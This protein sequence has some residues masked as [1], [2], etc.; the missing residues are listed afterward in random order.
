M[1]KCDYCDFFSRGGSDSVGNDYVLS[2]VHEADYYARLYQIDSF[3]TIYIGGGTPSL[4][5]AP[6]LSFLLSALQKRCGEAEEITLEMNPETLDGEKLSA[7]EEHGVSRL[8]VGVQSLTD[9]ALAS[10]HRHCSVSQTLRA[11]SLIQSVWHGEVNLDVMAGLPGQ[12]TPSFLRSLE[13]VISYHPEHLSL[14]TLT[15]EEGTPFA[16]RIDEGFPWNA[17][18]AD[19]EWLLGRKMLLDAS[20]SQYEVSN[21]AI[22]GHESRHNAAYWRQE[23][24]IGIGAGAVGTVYR[25]DGSPGIRWTNTADIAAY[26]AFWQEER[27]CDGGET[28]PRTEEMLPL[29]VE[30]FEYF[31]MGLRTLEGVDAARYR[32]RYHAVSPWGGDISLRLGAASGLWQRLLA[33]KKARI[34]DTKQHRFYALTAEGLLFLNDVLRSL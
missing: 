23:D 22:P 20:Y 30:E 6:Q 8:S 10:V 3:K 4:L 12:D 29:P 14:Y 21:F 1:A 7:A 34:Y 13:A 9:A 26:I 25:F 18:T 16:S 27:R 17:D 19:E 32:E 15:V 31:M 5:S 11:L 24:Y 33:E 2:L 28:L